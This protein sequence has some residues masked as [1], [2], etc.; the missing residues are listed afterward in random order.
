MNLAETHETIWKMIDGYETLRRICEGAEA[1]EFAAILG[2]SR[3]RASKAYAEVIK[4]LR[5]LL[6]GEDP[7]RRI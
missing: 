7:C 5:K 4:D 1:G 6:E 3:P 2:D